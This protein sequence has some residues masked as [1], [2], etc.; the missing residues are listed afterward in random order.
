MALR[1]GQPGGG[2][3]RGAAAFQVFGEDRAAAFGFGLVA[4]GPF[5]AEADDPERSWCHQGEPGMAADQGLG[6]LRQVEVA[7]DGGAER[8]QAEGVHGHP[9]L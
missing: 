9:H 7:L 4:A 1:A 6:V 3:Q 8:G 5:P 2:D